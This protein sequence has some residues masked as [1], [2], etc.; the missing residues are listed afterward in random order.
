MESR[1][2]C[3][4]ESEM[5]SLPQPRMSMEPEMNWATELAESVGLDYKDLFHEYFERFAST[6]YWLNLDIEDFFLDYGVA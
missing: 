1:S 6:D 3:F 2:C 4:S 5:T